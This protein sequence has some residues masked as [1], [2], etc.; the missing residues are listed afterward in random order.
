MSRRFR[1][2]QP[3]GSDSFL[4]VIA[5]IVGILIILI[6]VVGMKVANQAAEM[7][8]LPVVETTESPA[9]AARHEELMSVRG[10]IADAAALL[11]AAGNRHTQTLSQSDALAKTLR[12]SADDEGQLKAALARSHHRRDEQQDE[13]L[14][15]QL[16]LAKVQSQSDDLKGRQTNLITRLTSLRNT[17]VHTDLKLAK[18]SKELSDAE[19]ERWLVSL[20]TQRLREVLKETVEAPTVPID[21]LKHRLSPV[22]SFASD[23][24][25]HF[26]LSDGGVSHIPV[27]ALLN[28]LKSQVRSRGATIQ[29]FS[30][31]EGTVGPIEG[32]TMTYSVERE[33][34]SS[35]Q[36][37]QYGATGFRVAVSR[38]T[39]TPTRQLRAESAQEA[40]RPGSRFRQV[41]ET[42]HP[43]STV[44]IWT[45]PDSFA[46][47]PALREVAHALQ[48]KVAGRPMPEGTPIVGSPSGS[49]TRSQ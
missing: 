12:S 48:L 10:E 16:E 42:L 43:G 34:L 35:L 32:Y 4:D 44:T 21:R 1:D 7:P 36:S 2:E 31:Y 18:L 45:Y 27:E 41:V 30:R 20:E 29:R 39:I 3:F 13:T 25:V 47:F 37:M 24:E 5:N 11:E 26:R 9:V 33:R 46:D 40:V 6:V 23:E 8:E 38:W 17:T 14:V 15:N 19:D 22:S 28:R 49:Q